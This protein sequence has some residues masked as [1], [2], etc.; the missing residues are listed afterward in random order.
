MGN[1]FKIILKGKGDA[2]LKEVTMP[3]SGK[4]REEIE[5]YQ[6]PLT[7]VES[8]AIWFAASEFAPQRTFGNVWKHL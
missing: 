6:N 3:L 2:Y 1:T 4:P 5:N 7:N 8:V